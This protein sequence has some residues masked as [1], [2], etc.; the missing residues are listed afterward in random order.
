MEQTR[1][2]KCDCKHEFQDSRYGS[3]KRATTPVN[4]EQASKRFVV[5]CTV[6][7]REHN[8]GTIGGGE[9]KKVEVSR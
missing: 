1:I 5:R 4:K 7:G 2:V 8:L 9:V 3:G 6:C